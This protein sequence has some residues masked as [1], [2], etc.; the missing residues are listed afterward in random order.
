MA[1]S[2]ALR[3]S[4]SSLSLGFPGGMEAFGKSCQDGTEPTHSYPSVVKAQGQHPVR[5]QWCPSFSSQGQEQLRL[6]S[7]SWL[8]QLSVI[9]FPCPGGEKFYL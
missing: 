8:E 7:P 9:S 3:K 1:L 4:R 6:N 2:E 5:V